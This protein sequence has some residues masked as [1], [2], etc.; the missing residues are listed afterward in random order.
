MFFCK[1]ALLSESKRALNFLEFFC[2][3]SY[4]TTVTCEFLKH[5]L[6]NVM[7]FSFFML[8]HLNK[9]AIEMKIHLKYRAPSPSKYK[10]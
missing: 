7:W 4:Q 1:R 2:L 8:M 10:A 3:I 9:Q 5:A 6:R